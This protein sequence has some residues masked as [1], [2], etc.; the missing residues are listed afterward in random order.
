MV[1]QIDLVPHCRVVLELA[2]TNLTVVLVLDNI[3]AGLALG[4]VDMVKGRLL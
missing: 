2:Q 1:L 4:G 3:Q